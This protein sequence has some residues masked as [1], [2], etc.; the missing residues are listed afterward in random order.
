MTT[1][2]AMIVEDGHFRGQSMSYFT[3]PGDEVVLRVT[4]ALSLSTRAVENEE[5]GERKIVS[6]GG[7]RFRETTVKGELSATNHRTKVATLLVRRRFSGAES[8]SAA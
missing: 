7:R 6:I 8:T 1:A 2:A 4:K 5:E 3:N